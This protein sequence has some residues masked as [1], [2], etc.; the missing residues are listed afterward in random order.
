MSRPCEF[1]LTTRRRWAAPHRQERRG[2]PTAGEVAAGS[3]GDGDDMIG[4]RVGD[5]SSSLGA[6]RPAS[7]VLCGAWMVS[8]L[9]S[10]SAEGG[11]PGDAGGE[12]GRGQVSRLA[13]CS[14]GGGSGV[15]GP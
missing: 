4:G 7:K 5:A 9:L 11:E 15:D 13:I 12:P 3:S 6:W 10:S 1:Q 8:C 2:A 14:V